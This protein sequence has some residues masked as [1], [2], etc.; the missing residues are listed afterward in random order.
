MIIFLLLWIKSELRQK[1]EKEESKAVKF[2]YNVLSEIFVLGGNDLRE[3]AMES[4]LIGKI[5]ERLGLIS[6]ESKRVYNK[7]ESSR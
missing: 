5:L 4:N 2:I 1:W 6:K 7:D 3:K